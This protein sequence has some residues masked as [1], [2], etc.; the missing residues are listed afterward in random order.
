ML[1]FWPS[2]NP[3]PAR[4]WRN[5]SKEPW[6]KLFG[7]RVLRNPITGIT[8]CCARAATGHAAAA[9]LTSDMN[10]RR[11]TTSDSRA[12]HQ[13]DSTPRRGS[14]LHPSTWAVRADRGHAADNFSK[15]VA[16]N[17]PPHF[18]ARTSLSTRNRFT[19]NFRG[20]GLDEFSIFARPPPGGG[21]TDIDQH[22]RF[23]HDALLGA[24]GAGKLGTTSAS[25]S[26]TL[27]FA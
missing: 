15:E 6:A 9:P 27:A 23:I 17:R 24:T 3:A 5:A 1:T 7:D 16:Q 20:W 10:S 19:P 21:S 25:A 4:P 18:L 8:G 11:F 12:S 26:I 13:K 2:T 22:R 14:L